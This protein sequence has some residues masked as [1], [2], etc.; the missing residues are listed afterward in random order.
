[1]IFRGTPAERTVHFA[2]VPPE[3]PDDA[4]I[5]AELL[6]RSEGR[7]G[8]VYCVRLLAMDRPET[9]YESPW[10]PYAYFVRVSWLD[11]ARR[12]LPDAAIAELVG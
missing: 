2:F 11:L 8:C 7:K 12:P 6:A 5:M 9:I 3:E 1:M 10:T 4:P